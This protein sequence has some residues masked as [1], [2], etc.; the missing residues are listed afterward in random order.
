MTFEDVDLSEETYRPMLGNKSNLLSVGPEKQKKELLVISGDMGS[1]NV[2]SS[3]RLSED[4]SL[5][6]INDFN[7]PLKAEAFYDFPVAV[8]KKSFFFTEDPSKNIKESEDE[9]PSIMVV[10]DEQMNIEVMKA[11]IDKF[12]F[13]IDEATSGADALQLF[14]QRIQKAKQGEAQMYKV[15]L[16]DYSMPLMDGPQV[17]R[18]MRTLCGDLEGHP[19]PFICCCTAYAEASF[20]STALL[21]GMDE[22]LTKPISQQELQA[23]ITEQLSGTTP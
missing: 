20:K 19:A 9:L 13:P 10:D 16:L 22:F 3:P 4:T 1:M 17:A 18:A 15:V 7:V 12:G 6:L 8:K 2:T 23:V 21:S 14:E 5:Q 11:M